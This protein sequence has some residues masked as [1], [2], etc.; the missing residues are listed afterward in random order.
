MRREIS[1]G[2]PRAFTLIELLVVVAIIAILAAILMPALKTARDKAR[3][4][5]C[6]SQIK[7][8]GLGTQIYGNDYDEYLPQTT[9]AWILN[10]TSDGRLFV[11]YGK[12]EMPG[13]EPIG[14]NPIVQLI[15]VIARIQ[16]FVPLKCLRSAHES[17]KRL[18][19]FKDIGFYQ[20]CSKTAVV[21][22]VVDKERRTRRT[23]GG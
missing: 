7:Q 10:L 5:Q 22:V 8:Y 23:H 15:V 21:V 19:C 17:K 14:L 9:T 2:Q 4:A 13:K 16:V 20:R 6:M 1:P 12:I 3:C 11:Y 18:D